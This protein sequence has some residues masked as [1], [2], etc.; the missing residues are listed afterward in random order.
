MN[1]VERFVEKY[2]YY[3][4]GYTSMNHG[5][6]LA[7]I[8]KY[9]ISISSLQ[10]RDDLTLEHYEYIYEKKYRLTKD[11]VKYIPCYFLLLHPNMDIDL[12]I[13]SIK[14]DDVDKFCDWLRYKGENTYRDW[15]RHNDVD[16]SRLSRS[17]MEDGVLMT[18]LDRFPDKLW[19]WGYIMSMG[20]LTEEYIQSR[21][22]KWNWDLLAYNTS[23]P[24]EYIYRKNPHKVHRMIRECHGT[25]NKRK[26][27][28]CTFMRSIGANMISIA[29]IARLTV[30][31]IIDNQICGG[32]L[33]ENNNLD[34]EVYRNFPQILGMPSL[35][36][37]F[38][39]SL[40]DQYDI[41]DHCI[42]NHAYHYYMRTSPPMWF[43]DKHQDHLD[44]GLITTIADLDVLQK[45]RCRIEW[46]CIHNNP[47][48]TIEFVEKNIGLIDKE[49][50]TSINFNKDMKQWAEYV[51]VSKIQLFKLCM[52]LL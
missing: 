12:S 4:N 33:L 20:Y 22:Y 40:I 32:D 29:K 47:H 23:L 25:L 16:W 51:H 19:D 39:Q 28:T 37:V 46:D 6:S 41:L 35:H 15:L 3:R 17:T 34:V 2:I 14:L 11:N 7:F 44:W 1:P 31:D 13:L 49:H 18:L 52:E 24:I 10:Y 45:H 8:D 43:V 36:V 27:M 5:L 30:Q 21:P 42:D 50:I 9:H 26:D 38:N 48:L